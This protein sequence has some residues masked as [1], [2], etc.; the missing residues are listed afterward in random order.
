MTGASQGGSTERTPSGASGSTAKQASGGTSSRD[1]TAKQSNGGADE[2]GSTNAAGGQPPSSSTSWTTGGA[3]STTP[4][5]S[6]GGAA[7]GSDSNTYSTTGGRSFGIGGKSAV[8]GAGGTSA[9]TGG[10]SSTGGTSSKSSNTFG[11]S[12]KT[13]SSGGTNAGGTSNSGSVTTTPDEVAEAYVDAT[14]AVRA[15]VTKPSNYVGTWEPL[16]AVTWSDTVAASAQQWV[17]HLAATSCS[18]EHEQQH[19]YGENLAMG[20][21]TDKSY[22]MSPEAAVEGWAGEADNWTYSA[23]FAACSGCSS[24]QE[25]GHYTQLVWRKS[26]VIG[27][28]SAQCKSGN[29]YFTVI[30]CRYSPPGNYLGEPVF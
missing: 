27:C 1:S 22:V 25:Y 8:A 18:L 14:N 3:K 29:F 5:A 11:T 15:G 30:G 23:K 12:T 4:T 17:D 6:A 28:G 16:P 19:T 13:S 20:G 21:S 26:V 10:R 2:E 9:S 7:P 24:D